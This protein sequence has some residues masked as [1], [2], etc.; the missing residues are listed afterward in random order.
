MSNVRLRSL[1]VIGLATLPLLMGCGSSAPVGPAGASIAP[2]SAELFLTLD[3]SFDSGQWEAAGDLLD[4]FPDGDRGVEYVLRELSDE[5]IDFERDVKPALGPETD[6][7][8]LDLFSDEGTFVGL[9]QPDDEQKL[10]DLLAKSDEPV[11]T[12]EI[13][14]WTAFADSEAILDRFEDERAGGALDGSDDFNDALN[15]VE[16]ES[17][18]RLYLNG[19]AVQEGI[20]QEGNLPPGALAT[21]LPGGKFP[22]FALALK[23]EE[24]GVRLEGAA[25]LAGEDGGLV[26]EP[27]EAQLP[28]ELPEGAIVYV[29]FN[30]LGSQLSALKEFLAQV[31]PDFDRDV[32]RV[33][34]ELGLSLEEDIFPLLSGEGAFY[35]RSGFPIPEITLVTHVD[36]EGGAMETLDKLVGA[37][38][39]YLPPGGTPRTTEIAGI[40]ARELPLSPPFSLYYAAF[41]G[42]LVVTTSPGGISSLR[43]EG[44]RL[45][46]DSDFR[47]ALDEADVPDETTGIAY[48]NLRTAVSNLLNL[49]EM[50]GARLPPEVRVNLEPLEH[51][52]FY[53]TKDGSTLRFAAFLSID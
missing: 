18:A 35:I 7:V 47:A 43:E 13:E 8:G 19:S 5:G 1:L 40:E 20:E 4:E 17:L 2:A 6:I 14:G 23:A 51:L 15:E 46:D 42:H 26:P 22:S 34:A 53:G 30:D 36:D 32:A 48:V 21:L 38:G 9:T 52:V 39:E 11:V 24:N 41:D 37:L 28:K 25:K 44:D 3:T 27:F 45:A 50:S 12:R 49:A 31:E 29:G 10:E 16:G 33:E